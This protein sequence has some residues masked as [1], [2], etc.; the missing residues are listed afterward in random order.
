MGSRLK[1]RDGLIVR[2]GFT[3]ETGMI[4]I[5]GSLTVITG[6]AI[7]LQ[8]TNTG[9]SIGDNIQDVHTITGS[10]RVSGSSNFRGNVV[11][12]G[13]LTVTEGITGSLLGTASYATQA[14]SASW[15][16]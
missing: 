3:V 9:V 10:L 4:L 7:E 1:I 5:T 11:V 8:V 12:T 13:S 14:L 16:P 2:E 15:A 6:S